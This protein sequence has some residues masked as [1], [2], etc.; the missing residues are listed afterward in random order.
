MKYIWSLSLLIVLNSC[1]NSNDPKTDA[2]TVPAFNVEQA[3]KTYIE[4]KNAV[5]KA[6]DEKKLKQKLREDI[7]LE[8]FNGE[9][10]DVAEAEL[11]YDNQDIVK[12]D[13][14]FYDGHPI[15][16][17]H[18]F[19]KDGIPVAI[20]IADFIQDE[21]GFLDEKLT[22]ILFYDSQNN[23]WYNKSDSVE[24]KFSAEHRKE[25]ERLQKLAEKYKPKN[26]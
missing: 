26:K 7:S 22:E 12:I 11:W 9:G 3:E 10:L 2:P 17:K 1:N 19:I 6:R 5:S 20:E 18:W 24:T 13:S 25:W 23:K 4:I 14:R 15:G 16:T 21:E 8:S